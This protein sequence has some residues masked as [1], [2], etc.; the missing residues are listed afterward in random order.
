MILILLVVAILATGVGG[1]RMGYNYIGGGVSLVLF[2]LFCLI[3]LKII[4]GL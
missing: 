2:I 1:Y 4:P 3:V